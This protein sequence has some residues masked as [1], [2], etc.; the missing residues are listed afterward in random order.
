[1]PLETC[2]AY[3]AH[4]DLKRYNHLADEERLCVQRRDD[5]STIKVFIVDGQTDDRQTERG[6]L[7][8][9]TVVSSD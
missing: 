9:S 1:L 3:D 6:S 8:Y 5:A 7:V 4:I 2:T